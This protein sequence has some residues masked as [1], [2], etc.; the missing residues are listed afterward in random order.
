M[1]LTLIPEYLENRKRSGVDT[2]RLM[3]KETQ[4]KQYPK[5][6]VN[7][8]LGGMLLNINDRKHKVIN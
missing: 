1:I 5:F 3:P 4:W 2:L 7:P 6:C 8:N